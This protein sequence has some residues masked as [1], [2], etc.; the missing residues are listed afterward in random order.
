MYPYANY[1]LIEFVTSFVCLFI[2]FVFVYTGML[3]SHIAKQ[4]MA[5][6]VTLLKYI[7]KYKIK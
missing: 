7:S 3:Q 4:P 5:E 1:V 2:Y 6:Y